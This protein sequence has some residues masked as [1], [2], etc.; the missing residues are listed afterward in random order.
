MLILRW[1]WQV[2]THLKSLAKKDNL[3]E[4]RAKAVR[5]YKARVASLT[6]ERT[7]VR[8]RVQCMI[9][10]VVKLK[11]DLKHATSARAWAEGREDEARNSLRAAKGELRDELWAAQND[12]LES[13]DELQS[14]QYELQMVRDELLISQGE[15][16]EYKEE[17]R[18]VKDELHDKTM[19]LDGTRREAYEAANSAKRL[20]EECRG[21]GGDLHQQVTL[22]AQRDEVIGR[23]RDEACT[24]G[25][26][27]GLPFRGK[28]LLPTQAW[29]STLTSLVT[30]RLRS[31]SLLTILENRTPPL[32]PTPL[33]LPLL[34]LLMPDLPRTSSLAWRRF[35]FYLFFAGLGTQ[36][37]CTFSLINVPFY[38]FCLYLCISRCST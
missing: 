32:R 19:L 22:V 25:L 31:P 15:P 37:V 13:R 2:A 6:S 35:L 1:V 23:L 7:E 12:L 30:R 10:E 36:D 17:L 27:G 4:G 3:N 20:T 24:H 5:V 38:H 34:L 33:L 28:L 29:N 8:D 16:R 18:A 9:E 11:S 26:L 14:T 21:L